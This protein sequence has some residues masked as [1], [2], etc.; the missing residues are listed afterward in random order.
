[1]SSG[2]NV[3]VGNSNNN[4]I[5]LFYFFDNKKLYSKTPEHRKRADIT[6]RKGNRSGSR[7]QRRH[8]STP[9]PPPPSSRTH[10]LLWPHLQL[11]FPTMWVYVYL[12]KTDEALLQLFSKWNPL[13][14]SSAIK[15]TEKV[16]EMWMTKQ[17]LP[18]SHLLIPFT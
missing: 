17:A 12:S 14:Y 3:L 10:V 13:A 7:P 8:S 2:N 5:V 1:M 9:Y 4:V 11:C 16:T 6:T 15:S 18:F